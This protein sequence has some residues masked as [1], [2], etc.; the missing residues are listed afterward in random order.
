MS[1]DLELVRRHVDLLL[2]EA[3]EAG[4]P[5]D[6]VGRLL[7]QEAIGIWRRHRELRDIS[8]ELEFIAG[9]LDP[10]TDFEFMRP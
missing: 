4:V 7:V 8:S 3:R 6:V 2:G 1:P 10:E 5:D 9:S